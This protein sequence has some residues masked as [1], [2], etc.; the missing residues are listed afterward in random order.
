MYRRSRIT[1][2]VIEEQFRAC[3]GLDLLLPFDVFRPHPGPAQ[4]RTELD[5]LR[6]IIPRQ[7]TDIVS[8][9]EQFFSRPK[10]RAE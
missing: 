10:E 7:R 5:M 1:V 8:V 3:D 9:A 2:A 4:A 6:T